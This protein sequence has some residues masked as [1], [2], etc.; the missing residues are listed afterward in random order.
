MT[1]AITGGIG[2]GKSVVSR[3]L[4][5]LGF[6]VIDCD[7][8]A[9]SLMESSKE[10]KEQIRDRISSRVTDGITQPDRK[11]LAEIVFNN[12]N[13]RKELNTIV[14][15]ALRHELRKR[16]KNQEIGRL[17]FIEAAVLAESGL[18]DDCDQIWKVEA[19]KNDRIHRVVMRDKC[20][21]SH[22]K[23][24]IIAQESEDILIKKFSDKTEIIINTCR[25]SL[26]DQIGCRLKKLN[27]SYA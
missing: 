27:Y 8:E 24:R 7:L 20:D 15:E 6:Y 10:I 1:V 23:A 4:R 16:I 25:H 22:V 19:G 12:E 17:I 18:A 9:R 26:L 13:A 2:S 5:E 14:H 21:E 3:I 11:I